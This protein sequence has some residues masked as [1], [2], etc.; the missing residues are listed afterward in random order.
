MTCHGVTFPEEPQQ[1]AYPHLSMLRFSQP[2]S[3]SAT[4]M[5]YKS[6]SRFPPACNNLIQQTYACSSE[7]WS[8]THCHGLV[9]F[10]GLLDVPSTILDALTIRIAFVN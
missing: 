4:P 1:E 5:S 10:I 6:Y 7:G 9:S 8:D 3:I 2:S